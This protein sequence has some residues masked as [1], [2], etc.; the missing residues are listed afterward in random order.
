MLGS[1][2]MDPELLEYFDYVCDRIAAHPKYAANLES[3]A[4]AGEQLILN[5]HTHGPGQDYCVSVCFRNEALARLGL[6]APEEELA[7]IK[8][9]GKTVEECGPRMDAFAARLAERYALKRKPVV[10]LNG[11]PFAPD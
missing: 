1:P 8:G 10:F 7:H 3:A 11:A 9:I 6:P 2:R 5:Y 4:R